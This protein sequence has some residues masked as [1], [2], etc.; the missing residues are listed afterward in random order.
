MEWY[1]SSNNAQY[2]SAAYAYQAP[3]TAYGNSFE[4]EPPL[5]E[6]EHGG[7]AARMP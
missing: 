6:G 4:D 3:S 7:G 1:S 5:L 2:N